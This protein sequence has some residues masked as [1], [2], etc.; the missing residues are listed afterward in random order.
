MKK[1]LLIEDDPAIQMGVYD[2]LAMDNYELIMVS[3]GQDGFKKIFEENPDLVLLDIMLPGKNGFDICREV[4]ANGSQVPIMMLTSK[5][6]EIDRVLGLEVGADDYLT[7]P[8]S[9]KELSARIRAMFRRM[10][11]LKISN[12]TFFFGDIKVDFEKMDII[13]GI[14]KI[15]IS[16]KEFQI[17]NYFLN[18]EGQVVTRETLLDE[19]WGYNNYPTTRTVDNYILNLRKNIENDPSNPKHILTVHTMGYKFVK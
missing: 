8:F 3:D 4:R 16:V 1:V 15:N 9:V 13:K 19:V 2:G 11:N 5:T 10:D 7:K 18:H 14:N 12:S 17:L 6:D